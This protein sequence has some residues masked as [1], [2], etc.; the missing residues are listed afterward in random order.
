MISIALILPPQGRELSS[1]QAG[2]FDHRSERR[3]PLYVYT[4]PQDATPS[5]VQ[6]AELGEEHRPPIGGYGTWCARATVMSFT[7]APNRCL[8]AAQPTHAE[9]LAP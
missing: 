2:R 3:Y 5:G 4:A 1:D 8:V 6:I 7:G 9:Q